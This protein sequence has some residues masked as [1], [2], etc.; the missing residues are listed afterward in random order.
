MGHEA[1]VSII[2]RMRDARCMWR[3]YGWIPVLGAGILLTGYS[4][5]LGE[6]TLYLILILPVVLANGP[7]GWSG[8]ALLI[9]GLLWGFLAS[10][11]AS[12]MAGPPVQSQPPERGS[13]REGPAPAPPSGERRMGGVVLIGP[14]PV[15][16]APN[17]RV[18]MLLLLASVGV[19]LVMF[20]LL[21]L[22][23]GVLLV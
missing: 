7:Y 2:Y 20:V 14:I 18:A 3:R 9:G 17:R 16:F 21:L 6:S 12:M 4:V 22:W 19:V 15:I 23:A 1:G 11:P 5:W 10:F 8:A 13:P